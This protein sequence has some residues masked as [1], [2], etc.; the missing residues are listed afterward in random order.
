[1]G[2]T[3]KSR[4]APE[5]G[6]GALGE[7]LQPQIEKEGLARLALPESLRI[8][9]SYAELFLIAWSQIVGFEISPVSDSSS[10]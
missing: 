2:K 7:V 6:F 1:V 3:G 10:T 5:S 9:T 4:I 8:V